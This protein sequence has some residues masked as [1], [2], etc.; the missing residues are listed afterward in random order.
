MR[1]A[2]MAIHSSSQ[3]SAACRGAAPHGIVEALYGNTTSLW[4]GSPRFRAFF[5]SA[6]SMNQRIETALQ[7]IAFAAFIA[8]VL[9]IVATS[10]TS[11]STQCMRGEPFLPT[12]FPCF[13]P[14]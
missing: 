4:F 5:R 6:V 8:A 3:P 14:R 10:L 7:L 2:V 13:P 9:I 11:L 12:I 1:V